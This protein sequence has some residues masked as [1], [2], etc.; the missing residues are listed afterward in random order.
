VSKIKK[1][2]LGKG[3]ESLLDGYSIENLFISPKNEK[4]LEIGDTNNNVLEL[5]ISYIIVNKDQPR[6]N[7]NKESLE[8]LAESIKSQGLIQ[9][10]VVEKIDE[11]TYSIVAGERRYRASKLIGLEKV[12]VYIK[13]V[14][15][16]NRLI[17]SLIE[18]IQRE[19]LNAIEEAK[20]YYK[21]IQDTKIT[22][23]EL[24]EAVGKSRS[25]ISNS[26]RLLNLPENMQQG[27]IDGNYTSGHARAW[28]SLKNPADRIIL[29]EKLEKG[30]L[31]V[32]EAE[33]IANK[34]N[35]GQRN[36]ARKE[37]KVKQNKDIELV[38]TQDK[39][40]KAVGNK[41]EIKGTLEKG[42]LLLKYNHI[43]ELEEI[44]RKLSNGDEL[45]WNVRRN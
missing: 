29:L 34:L 24:S 14:N 4:D 16:K 31:S 32:R 37:K 27:I 33:N 30:D 9:P 15:N 35:L 23:E 1:K 38:E 13:N 17:V 41:V 45:F 20:A 11:K 8:N 5:P 28:L 42:T 19:D 40:I 12:P 18:N 7:F 44:F 39:F 21:I 3:M 43:E 25:A 6:K 26:I 2:G 22:Q 36:V 10:I